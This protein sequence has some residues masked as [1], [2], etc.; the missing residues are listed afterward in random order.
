M[1]MQRAIAALHYG[2]PQLHIASALPVTRGRDNFVLQVNHD[3][4][5]RFP[6]QR[7]NSSA[8]N[9]RN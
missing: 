6:T 5:F 2:F 4:I 7:S 9:T 1:S 8:D 3:L